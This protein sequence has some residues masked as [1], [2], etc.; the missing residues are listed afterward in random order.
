M[1]L[2]FTLPQTGG[3]ERTLQLNFGVE[4]VAAFLP[5][6]W[7]LQSYIQLTWPHAG[8]DWASMLQEVDA[9]YIRM[10]TEIAK[11]QPLLVVTPEP[12]RVRNLLNGKVDM[13]KVCFVQCDTNDTWARD[14]GFITML[15]EQGPSLIDFCFN[16]WGL[17]FA[18]N[19]D[20]QINRHLFASQVLQGAYRSCLDFVLEGGSIESDGKGTLL[21]TSTCL[22]SPN[23]NDALNRMDIETKLK[24]LFHLEQVLWL[25]YGFLKG[26]DTDSHVDTLARFCPSDTIVYVQCTN[27]DDEHYEELCKMEEQLHSFRTLDG[28]PYRLLPLPLPDA[29]VEDGQ[30]LPATYAN[31]LIMNEA[32]LYPTYNQPEKDEVAAKVLAEAFPKYEIVGVDCRVLIRQHG[33]LHCITMQYPAECMNRQ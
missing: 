18:A 16:G 24:S 9:C 27:P 22:L 28:K 2:V 7:H 17:K 5:S 19:Y 30:R 6:E 26:D 8:T 23:R 10:A 1:G 31:F 11:R 21:T 3:G 4:T 20:N 29:I 15:T 33:S 14:H 13:G 25:D 12:E 32:I